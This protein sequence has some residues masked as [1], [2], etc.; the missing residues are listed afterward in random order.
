MRTNYQGIRIEVFQKYFSEILE[1]LN[2]YLIPGE[3]IHFQIRYETKKNMTK[4]YYTSVQNKKIHGLSSCK[5]FQMQL[6]SNQKIETTSYWI[7]TCNLGANKKIVKVLSSKQ[8]FNRHRKQLKINLPKW[9]TTLDSDN[10][11][12]CN[13][14]PEVA[15]IIQEE[16]SS[17]N[18]S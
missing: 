17:Y 8:E 15:Y 10:L 9:K 14:S 12:D 4:H 7:Q 18:E 6:S 5:I 1:I 2:Q 11:R 13:S 16:F 3:F